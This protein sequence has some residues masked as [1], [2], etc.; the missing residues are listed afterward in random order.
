MLWVCGGYYWT[1]KPTGASYIHA[2]LLFYMIAYIGCSSSANTWRSLIVMH[3]MSHSQGSI[4]FALHSTFFISKH[5]QA[6]LTSRRACSKKHKLSLTYVFVIPQEA[7]WRPW[8]TNFMETSPSEANNHS[9]IKEFPTILWNQKIHYHFRTNLPLVPV[10]NQMNT[11]H[12]T[13]L[14]IFSWI[15]PGY[16]TFTLNWRYMITMLSY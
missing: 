3:L 1:V 11:V 13:P 9:A 5:L 2:G 8:L 6:F 16:N 10:L 12:T 7:M 4:K 14:I 15:V